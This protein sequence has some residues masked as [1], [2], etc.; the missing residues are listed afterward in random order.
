MIRHIVL[1]KF[2]DDISRERRELIYDGLRALV[3]Q[4]DG[5]INATF[6]PNVSPEGLS[7]GFRDGFIMDL[8]DADARDRYLAHPVHQAAGARLVEA[9]EGGLEGVLPFDMEI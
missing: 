6:G 2:R 5:L 8:R 1:I 4:I 9:A 3:G 7:K